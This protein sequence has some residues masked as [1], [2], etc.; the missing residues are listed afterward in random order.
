MPACDISKAY[1]ATHGGF[2]AALVHARATAP[3]AAQT[4]VLE[5][6]DAHRK[7]CVAA[8]EVWERIAKVWERIGESGYAPYS[9]DRILLWSVVFSTVQSPIRMRL[10]LGGV[11]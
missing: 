8:H 7:P 3:A 4:A 10:D 9:S 6:W 11:L 5:K 2:D 1:I